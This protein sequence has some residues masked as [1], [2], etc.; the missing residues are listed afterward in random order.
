[1]NLQT[2]KR[3]AAELLNVGK[4][5]VKFDETRVNDIKE[6]ITKSDIRSLIK[7]GVITKKA[8]NFQSR[9]RARLIKKQKSKGNSK[10]PGSVKRKTLW[11]RKIRVLRGFLRELRA[12]GMLETK[13]YRNLSLRSKGGYFRSKRHLKLYINEKNIVKEKK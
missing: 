9:A 10:G 11:V 5:K 2:Q 3:I 8:V 6:A 1:M 7:E 12:K 4:S 13:D